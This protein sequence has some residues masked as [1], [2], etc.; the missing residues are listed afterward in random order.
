MRV[1]VLALLV[2]CQR[3]HEVQILFGPDEDTISVGFTCVDTNN[4][5]IILRA[6]T[7]PG[8]LQFAL[9]VDVMTMGK[10]ILGCRGEE[11]IDACDEPGNCALAKSECTVVTLQLSSGDDAASIIEKMRTELRKQNFIVT[12]DAPDTPVVIR[13]TLFDLQAPQTS[14]ECP[15]NLPI[16]DAVGCAHSCPVQLDDIDKVS[17]SLGT[18]TRQCEGAVRLCA[19]FPNP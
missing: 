3:S 10:Q 1:L 9:R 4:D 12:N 11:L 5:L 17:V 8:E 18:L 13:V 19:A 6:R 16:A 7:A 2:A 14:L 15:A